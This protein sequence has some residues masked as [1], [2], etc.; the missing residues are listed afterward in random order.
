MAGT[1][2]K[3][4][5]GQTVD[6]DRMQIKAQLESTPKT[7]EVAKRE[8]MITAK[9]KRKKVKPVEETVEEAAEDTKEEK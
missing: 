8:E 9:R 5:R 3:S 7:S 4:A 6:F 2:G 1:V